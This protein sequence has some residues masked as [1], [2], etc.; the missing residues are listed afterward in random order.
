MNTEKQRRLI[1]RYHS[2]WARPR[3]PERTIS[4]YRCYNAGTWEDAARRAVGLGPAT[5]FT[6]KVSASQWHLDGVISSCVALKMNSRWI[7][8][9]EFARIMCD[10]PSRLPHA[11]GDVYECLAAALAMAYENARAEA[12]RA[13]PAVVSPC[14]FDWETLAYDLHERGGLF[15]P[16]RC[17]LLALR[18]W[19][20]HRFRRWRRLAKT[21]KAHPPGLT[22]G[23]WKEPSFVSKS[24][25]RRR[26]R[27]QIMRIYWRHAKAGRIAGRWPWNVGIMQDVM[28]PIHRK[29]PGWKMPRA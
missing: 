23:P 3:N 14:F 11:K 12:A 17:M 9:K 24:F 28:P 27:A 22:V 16:L 26:R 10:R 7:V 29:L 15:T 8:I 6:S 25:R 13:D 5:R 4:N 21:H 19:H 18:A 1:L 2:G 20:I